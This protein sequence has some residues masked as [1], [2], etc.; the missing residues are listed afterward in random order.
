MEYT[1]PLYEHF[2]S[3]QGEGIHAG[4]PAYFLR[5]YGCPIKCPWCDS[6]GTWHPNYR[7]KHIS[8]FTS[9]ELIDFIRGGTTGKCNFVVVTGGEPAI[10]DLRDLCN[11]L[12][13]N[14]FRS[15]LETSGAY[16]VNGVFDWVTV[17]PKEYKLP[18]QSNIELADE[19]KLI[20][21]KIGCI[22]YW[23][24]QF[25]MVGKNVILNP[26]WSVS[27]DP[28]ILN[29]ITQSVQK[30]GFRAGLQ[31]HKYYKSDLLDSNCKQDVPLGG[32]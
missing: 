22:E 26:E 10:Y 14:G 13:S 15:H 7:P 27:K 9:Q 3:W 20:V 32:K 28:V 6:A 17:S 12:R 31:L 29:Y 8:K 18:L 11:S 30:Y 23:I 16:P 21:D 1:Y 2:Y 19:V 25:N 4:L 24:S 5:L